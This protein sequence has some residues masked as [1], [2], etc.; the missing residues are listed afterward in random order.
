MTSLAA[1]IHARLLNRARMEGE[2]F[3]LVLTRYGIER[4]LY[5]LYKAGH[6]DRFILKGAQLLMIYTEERYR[7]TRDLDL[8]G[9]GSDDS[10]ALTEIFRQLCT[11]DVAPDGL[12]F[13]PSTVVAE[14]IRNEGDYG[15]VRVKL[16]AAPS[17]STRAHRYFDQLHP[18]EL[19]VRVKPESTF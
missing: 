2:D 12:A 6:A 9:F 19:G 4:L 8:L 18:G 10:D 15:G 13:D 5:R 17:S 1:S 11:L 16:N 7:P 3:N 14:R